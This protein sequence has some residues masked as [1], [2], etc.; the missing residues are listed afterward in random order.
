MFAPDITTGVPIGFC[1][2]LTEETSAE[3]NFFQ[4]NCQNF[5]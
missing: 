1:W 3:M 4:F 5:I 2:N